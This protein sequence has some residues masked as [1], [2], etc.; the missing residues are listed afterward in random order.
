MKSASSVCPLGQPVKR[1][2]SGSSAHSV[3]T[4][5]M[6]NVRAWPGKTLSTFVITVTLTRTPSTSTDDLN[7]KSSFS[8][9]FHFVQSCDAKHAVVFISLADNQSH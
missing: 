5:L 1:G 4:G 9:L 7:A 6:W 8:P 3:K 2:K